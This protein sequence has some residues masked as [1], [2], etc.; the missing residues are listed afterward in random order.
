MVIPE[1]EKYVDYKCDCGK[2]HNFSSDVIIGDGVV[3]KVDAAVDRFAAKKVY[4]VSDKNTFPICGSKVFDILEAGGK[5]VS[6]YIFNQERV[7]PDEAS[8]GLAIMH[9]SADCDVIVGVGSGVINDICKIVA[10]VGGKPYIIVATAPSMDGY[11]SASSSM[12]RAGLKIS[13]NSKAPDVIIGDT[14]ILCNAP[15]KMMVS[16][17]GD[18]L[19]K[20]ISICEW[21]IANIITGEYYCEEIATLVRKALKKCTDNAKGLLSRDKT[22]V[23]AVFEGLIISGAAMEYAGVSRP[24]SG[25]E[26]YISHVL[27]MRGLSLGTP[28]DFHGIQCAIGTLACIKLYSELKN[29]TPEREKALANVADYDYSAWCEKLRTFLGEGAESMILLE[30]KEG[31]YDKEK[32]T[33]RLERILLNW[34][35]IIRIIDEELPQYNEIKVLMKMLSAPCS[36]SD[37]GIENEIFPQVFETTR[38]IRDKY[39]LSRLLWDLGITEDI[40]NKFSFE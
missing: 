19:A 7:V 38:D 13:L 32:H 5:T 2:I 29:I 15:I 27:D 20:Y 6:K 25:A 16:G 28:V 33:E 18:M 4:M 40:L 10:H 22:S 31:K 1:I 23:K 12:E 26:H 36:F 9:Y 21:R 8:V 37:I 11:A 17:M 14:D 24:A 35:S 34:D 30:E 3:G 39:I